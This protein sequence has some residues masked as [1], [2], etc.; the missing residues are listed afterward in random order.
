MSGT[1]DLICL[2]HLR[3][4]FVYQRPNHLMSRCAKER[5]VFFFEEPILD[6]ESPRLETSEVEP[7]LFRV[8]PHLPTAFRDDQRRVSLG[9]LLDEMIDDQRIREY[10]LWLYTPMALEFCSH[11]NP[12]VTIYDCMD[13][14][15]MFANAPKILRDYELELF[16]RANLVFTGG[17]SLYE[18]KRKQHAN[19]HAFPSSVD[20]AHFGRARSGRDEPADQA[21]IPHTKMG[22]LGVFDERMDIELVRGIA[23]ARPE[24]QIVLIGPVVKIDPNSLPR[25]PNIHYLGQKSYNDLPAYLSGWDVALLTFAMNDATRFISPT[26]TPEYLAAGRPVVSTP[27]KDIVTPYGDQGLVRIAADAPA[28]VEAIEATLKEGFAPKQAEVDEFLREMSW[29]ETWRRMH[30][31]IEEQLARTRVEEVQRTTRPRAAAVEEEETC[32]TI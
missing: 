23:E 29:D 32:S 16:K 13:E 7:N 14:L 21:A 8:V 26:K 28:F 4:N 9:Q 20:R 10:A 5:R 17:M 24:W 19:V 2:S 27:I 18:S 15:S 6:A 25:L 1:V 30:V 31:L 12:A 3:W 22:F 11:L